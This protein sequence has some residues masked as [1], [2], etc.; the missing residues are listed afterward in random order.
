MKIKIE[1][2]GGEA[3]KLPNLPNIVDITDSEEDEAELEEVTTCWLCSRPGCDTS[4][5]YCEMR[6]CGPEHRELHQPADQDEP[7]PF[8]VKYK[9]GVGRLMVAARDIDQGELI[10]TEECFAQ[11]PN[12]TLTSPHCMECYKPCAAECERC[13]W[14]VCNPDCANGPWHTME[15][16]T[17]AA[18]RDRLDLAAMQ[19]AEA[20]YWPVSA[21]RVLLA[22][23]DSPANKSVI[24]RMLSH[25]EQHAASKTWPQYQEHLVRTIR[26]R[27]GLADT[28]TEE[29]VEHASG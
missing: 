7:W 19:K 3:A 27:L 14:P 8:L 10:F 21:L 23:R 24:M 17:L 9:P 26:E 4:E 20:Q 13:G 12:H 22:C 29:E 15:C 11:G 1:D 28:F 5:F 25:R 6:Y 18:A 2:G 16:A